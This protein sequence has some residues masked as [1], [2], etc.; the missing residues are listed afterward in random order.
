MRDLDKQQALLD[1]V[2]K[3]GGV[4]DVQALDVNKESSVQA[5]VDYIKDKSKNK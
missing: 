3:R 5:V 4:V 1:E 2:T